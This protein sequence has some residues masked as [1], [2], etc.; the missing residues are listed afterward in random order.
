MTMSIIHSTSTFFHREIVYSLSV[1]KYLLELTHNS[2][3]LLMSAFTTDFHNFIS[4]R[5]NVYDT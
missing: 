1:I 2:P 5:F 3:L 4:L